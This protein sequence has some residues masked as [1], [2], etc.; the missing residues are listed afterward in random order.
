MTSLLGSFSFP[1]PEWC[2]KRPL[3]CL[4][5]WGPDAAGGPGCAAP[6]HLCGEQ[7]Q[8]L[9]VHAFVET[10]VVYIHQEAVGAE[11]KPQGDQV[12]EREST[13]Q[14][15]SPILKFQ[16]RRHTAGIQPP[17]CTCHLSRTYLNEDWNSEGINPL[18]FRNT[19]EHW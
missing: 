15:S 12:G 3:L 8:I 17:P 11:G 4:L 9:R 10:A 18:P 6:T 2:S 5:L 16:P 1:R 13:D 19:W 14:T 7:L